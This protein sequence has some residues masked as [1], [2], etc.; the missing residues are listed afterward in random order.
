MTYSV[1]G[2]D[3]ITTDIDE[4]IDYCVAEDYHDSDDD[5]FEEWVNNTY[6]EV[7]IAGHTYTP[8]E[9]I[10]AFDIVEE[11]VS[12]YR[13]S[14]D[15]DDRDNADWDLRHAVDGEIVCIQNYEVLCEIDDCGYDDD[16]DEYI[17]N[18]SQSLEVLRELVEC[19]Q[20]AFEEELKFNEKNK[21]SYLDLFQTIGD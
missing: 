2:T 21:D 17:P 8:Y 9:A 18:D 10:E 19:E 13:E 14:M 11:V 4:V 3:F 5:Y 12:D 7:Y 6:Q 20:L 15:E 1:R 16:G